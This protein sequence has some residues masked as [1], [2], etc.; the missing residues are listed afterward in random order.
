MKQYLSPLG[1]PKTIVRIDSDS[2]LE[3]A[4]FSKSAASRLDDIV[5]RKSLPVM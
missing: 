1:N 2:L 4:F 5:P 3:T